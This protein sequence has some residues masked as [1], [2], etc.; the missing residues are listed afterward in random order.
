MKSTI[1]LKKLIVL[2]ILFSSGSYADQINISPQSVRLMPGKIFLP[3]GFDN[4][5]NVQIVVS[6]YLPNTCY[7][8]GNATVRVDENG[9]KIFVQNTAYVYAGCW[10]AEMT[11]PYVHTVNVGILPKGHYQVLVQD[12]KDN[13]HEQG[14]MNISGVSTTGP[15][16][17]LYA[18]VQDLLVESQ[19]ATG[20]SSLVIRGKFSSNCMSL[21]EVKVLYRSSHVI[22]VLPIAN[23]AD[24]RDC[25]NASVPFESEVKIQSPWKGDTLVYV[26]S[27]NGQAVSKVIEF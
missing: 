13:F 24:N 5:D 20:Q 10:C 23:L 4:N 19:P 21:Q 25:H 15:D 18:P 17:Y 2:G 26:R 7:K 3:S 6:G 11:I 14:A 22:E 8:A 12:Q 16:D 27:L 9:K 1:N